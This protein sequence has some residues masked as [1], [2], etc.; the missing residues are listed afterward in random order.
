M[1]PATRGSMAPTGSL[2]SPTSAV[3]GDDE[4]VMVE[5]T[6]AGP[7]F[8]ARSAGTCPISAC[9]P[10]ELT[11]FRHEGMSFVGEID[12]R[13]PNSLPIAG[14]PCGEWREGEPR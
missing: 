10:Q 2:E 3:A 11:G 4:V 13:F 12:R 6:G 1:S 9:D 14:P 5:E 8:V 7:S